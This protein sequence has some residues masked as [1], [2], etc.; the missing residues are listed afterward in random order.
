[1]TLYQEIENRISKRLSE[2]ASD[3]EKWIYYL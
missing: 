3:K 2:G 1:M